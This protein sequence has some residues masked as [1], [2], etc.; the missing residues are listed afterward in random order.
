M[1][2]CD[3]DLASGL[4]SSSVDLSKWKCLGGGLGIER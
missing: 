2:G 4:D 3:M 1:A